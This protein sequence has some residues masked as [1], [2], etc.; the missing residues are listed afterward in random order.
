MSAAAVAP[1]RPRP[2]LGPLFR[3]LRTLALLHA[4]AYCALL[5]AWVIPGLARPTFVLGLTHG[6]LWI[7]LSLATLVAC[8]RRRVGWDVFACVAVL[9]AVI[10]LAGALGYLREERRLRRRV[11]RRRAG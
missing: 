4:G 11:A 6:L 2:E 10:P 1:R 3:G 9:A 7:A 8:G 5:V